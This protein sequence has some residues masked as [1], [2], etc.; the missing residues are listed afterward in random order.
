MQNFWDGF[1]NRGTCLE[2]NAFGLLGMG[3]AGSA[4]AGLLSHLIPNVAA[5]RALKNKNYAEH[6]GNHFSSGLFNV[7]VKKTTAFLEGTANVFA[8]EHPLAQN[9]ARTLGNKLREYLGAHVADFSSNNGIPAI[10]AALSGN[11]PQAIKHNPEVAHAV[12]EFAKQNEIH[13][14][15][16]AANLKKLHKG[17]DHPIISNIIPN[18]IRIPTRVKPKAAPTF[19]APGTPEHEAAAM[20]EA[21]DQQT[22]KRFIPKG[23]RKNPYMEEG[24]PSGGPRLSKR[25]N[26]TGNLEVDEANISNKDDAILEGM[27]KSFTSPKMTALRK[28]LRPEKE[29]YIPDLHQILG[30]TESTHPLIRGAGA[31][32]GAAAAGLIDPAMGAVNAYKYLHFSNPKLRQAVRGVFKGTGGKVEDSLTTNRL[33]GAF[34]KGLVHDKP[35]NPITNFMHRYLFSG[36]QGEAAKTLNAVGR[37]GAGAIPPENRKNVYEHMMAAVHGVPGAMQAASPPAPLAERLKPFALP[38]AATAAAGGAAYAAGRAQRNKQQR[39]Q[40]APGGNVLPFIQPPQAMEAPQ[41]M[42]QFQYGGGQ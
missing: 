39:P 5:L 28:K 24:L 3:A 14:L 32:T 33:T 17:G 41:T 21:M 1:E 31:M 15:M 30:P 23:L 6:L 22:M 8:P 29:Q 38:A 13:P 9:S 26:R 35:L 37:A 25:T 7:P 16:L 2:K 36:V 40:V 4:A 19:H 20:Q 18:L 42:Q 34:E 12:M 10:Q 11:L 27:A